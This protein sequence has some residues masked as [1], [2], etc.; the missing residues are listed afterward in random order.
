MPLYDYECQRCGVFEAYH[1][2]KDKLERCPTCDRR[3]TRLIAMSVNFIRPPDMFWENENGG[4]GRY[5]GQLGRKDD[6]AAYC[7][8]RNELAEKAKRR[9]QTFEKV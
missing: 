3:V 9:G 5:C 4:K 2:M 1:G 7:R 6:P 8:S